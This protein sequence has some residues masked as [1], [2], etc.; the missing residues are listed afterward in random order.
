[1]TRLPKIL[2]VVSA[3]A[4]VVQIILGYLRKKLYG[5]GDPQ[6][7]L[8]LPGDPAMGRTYYHYGGKQ[9]MLLKL[10]VCFVIIFIIS[11]VLAVILSIIT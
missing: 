7:H 10:R 11:L 4:F 8:R 1:M 2:Y 6:D 5:F 3:V 9:E